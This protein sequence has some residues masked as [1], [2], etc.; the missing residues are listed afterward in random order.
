MKFTRAKIASALQRFVA[1][2]LGIGAAAMSVLG[3]AASPPE[4]EPSADWT[5]IA[6]GFLFAF[7]GAL[8]FVWLGRRLSGRRK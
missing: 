3:D 6:T 4:R 5:F 1:A 8:L 2:T 7:A